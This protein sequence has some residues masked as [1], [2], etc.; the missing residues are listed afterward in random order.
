MITCY[1]KKCK[2]WNPN[3]ICTKKKPKF[4]VDDGQC[5]SFCQKNED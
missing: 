2:Y 4:S 5:L 1:L 3:Y